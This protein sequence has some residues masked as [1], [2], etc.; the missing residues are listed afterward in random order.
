MKNENQEKIIRNVTNNTAMR[1]VNKTH[2][3]EVNNEPSMTTRGQSEPMSTIIERFQRGQ[4][5]TGY[6]TYHDSEVNENFESEQPFKKSDYDLS[7]LDIARENVAR[8][9]KEIDDAKRSKAKAQK[10]I[11]DEKLVDE[12]LA[13]RQHNVVPG[14]TK[15]VEN[16]NSKTE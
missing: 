1:Y 8:V 10:A 3:G 4:V 9:K 14:Q 13:R 15:T 7:D 6:H 5:I 11:D 16:Q 12:I 2:K